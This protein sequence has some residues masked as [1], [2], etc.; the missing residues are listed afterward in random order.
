[1]RETGF[2]YRTATPDIATG[3]VKAPRLLDPLLRRI[4]PAGI[5]GDRRGRY[6]ALNRFYLDGPAYGGLIGHVLDA[7][8][9]LR[10]HL[11]DGELDGQRVLAAQTARAMRTIDRPGKPF[12]HGT[13]WFRRPTTA[14][15]RWVEHFGSGVGFWNVMRLYPDQGLGVVLMGNSTTAFD[16]DPLFALLTDTSRS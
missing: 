8:R 2:R 9:F 3:Y 7:S 11:R 12:D 16:F 13:G 5:V 4:L 15:D 14:P 10:M 1:M 6:L